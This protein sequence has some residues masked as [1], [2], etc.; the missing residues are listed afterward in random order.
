[1]KIINLKSSIGRDL[2]GTLQCEHC[3]SLQELVGGYDDSHW[4][5]R[6]LPAFHCATC[7]RN[8]EG[9]L[10]SAEVTARNRANGVNG[11]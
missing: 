11:V 7:G 4:H 2:Y 10:K 1:M 8:R 3:D 6:V 5:D 9:E